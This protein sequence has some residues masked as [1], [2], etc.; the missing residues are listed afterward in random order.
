LPQLAEVTARADAPLSVSGILPLSAAKLADERL[1]RN[2][3]E[4]AAI[5]DDTII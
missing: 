2:N 3:K 1:P 4:T 5:F